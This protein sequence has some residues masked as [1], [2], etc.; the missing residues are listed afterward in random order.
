MTMTITSWTNNDERFQEPKEVIEGFH[1]KMSLNRLPPLPS[2]IP[3]QLGPL[4]KFPK[5]S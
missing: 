1:G 5:K 3:L 2:P 4:S